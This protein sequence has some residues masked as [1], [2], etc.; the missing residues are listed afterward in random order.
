MNSYAG[1][2]SS[3]SSEGSRV[4]AKNHLYYYFGGIGVFGFVPHL[5]CS[6]D[7]TLEGIR[8]KGASGGRTT[9]KG[10]WLVFC[11]L[12]IAYALFSF[13]PWRIS[14]NFL[15]GGQYIRKSVLKHFILGFS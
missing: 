5:S 3:F 15:S 2:T 11:Y 9:L 12:H 14:L 4:N 7:V 13:W 1:Q 6:E 8:F 10:P